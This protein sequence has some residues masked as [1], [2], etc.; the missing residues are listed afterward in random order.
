[1]TLFHMRSLCVFCGSRVGRSPA[2]ASAAAELG[3]AAAER[4]ILVVTGGGHVGLMGVVADAALAAGGQVHGVIP[5]RLEGKELAH[6]GLNRLEV[7]PSMHARKTRMH[8]LSEAFCA[9]PGGFGTLDEVFEA[10]TWSQLG[11][12]RKPVGFLDVDGY[13]APLLEWI[14]R[15]VDEGFVS[16]EHGALVI[17]RRR[18]V[19]LLDALAQALALLPPDAPPP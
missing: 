5:E 4:G 9:L 19:E 13:Y 10:L 3:R 16:P 11:L 18:A 6:Q 17:V 15:S 2:H 14:R 1:M 7:T 8:A 12:H